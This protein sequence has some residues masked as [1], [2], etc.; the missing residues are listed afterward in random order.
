MDN[1]IGYI[2]Q[3]G[4]YTDRELRKTYRLSNALVYISLTSIINIRKELLF[5]N[6][7]NYIQPHSFDSDIQNIIH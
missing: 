3:R 7:F 4:S 5:F 1:C 2:T 6:I